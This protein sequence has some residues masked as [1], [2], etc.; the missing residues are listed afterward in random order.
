MKRN[1]SCFL[2]GFIGM[3]TL[4]SCKSSPFALF[5]LFASAI[6]IGIAATDKKEGFTQRTFIRTFIGIGGYLV[7]AIVVVI[8]LPQFIEPK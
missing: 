3:I 5:S 4:L 8:F 6:A 2:I 7:G 1:L